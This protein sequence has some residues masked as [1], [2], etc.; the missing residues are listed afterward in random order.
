MAPT[1]SI[2]AS[3]IES[4]RSQLETI[5]KA[6]VKPGSVEVTVVT[7][8]A[9]GAVKNAI[10]ARAQANRRRNPW[11][12]NHRSRVLIAAM[13]PGLFSSSPG[14]RKRTEALVATQ[15]V[16]NVRENVTGQ[17]NEDGSTFRPLTARYARHKRRR[18][19]FTIPILKATN[20]LIGSLKTR[21]QRIT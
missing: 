11:Y 15:L 16:T 1:M 18:V 3:G 17:E 2:R 14:I 19:G 6:H 21:V 5:L 20:D 10:I 12:L 7:G 4:F 9:R 13:A 8:G